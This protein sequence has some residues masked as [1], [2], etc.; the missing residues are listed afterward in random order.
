MRPVLSACSIA[1]IA[2]TVLGTTAIVHSGQLKDTFVN[3]T[4]HPAIEY[5]ARPTTDPV[6]ELNRR[7]R[8][9]TTRLQYDGPSG[10]LRSVL[11]ALNVPVESQ[12]AV[13]VKDSV[14]AARISPGNPRTIF[15]NDSVA[16]GWVRGGFVEL[17]SQ[18]PRQG[19]IF[20]RLERSW[21]GAPLFTR[22]DG[23]LACHN[24]YASTGVPGMLVR[25]VGQY[26]VDHHVPLEQRWG[27]WYVTGNHGTIEHQGN[28]ELEK[29]FDRPRAANPFN[30]PSA[31]GKFDLAGYLSPH[32]DIVALLVFEHQMHMMNLLSRI[33]W[34]ARVAAYEKRTGKTAGSV[35][36]PVPV[37][38]AA[39]EVVDYL[40][41]VDEA[42]MGDAVRG[43][44]SFA[45]KFAAQGPRDRQGRS[46]RQLDLTHRLMRYPCSYMIYSPLFEALPADAKAAIYQRM[47]TI[48][49]G[50]D[51]AAKYSRLSAVDRRAIIDILRDTKKDLPD[52]FRRG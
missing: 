15:F 24:T 30:W 21:N 37:G 8:D 19:V 45:E 41:F 35:D 9:G 48:L 26:E 47:W 12:M 2:C 36:E 14:Q 10:Y 28:V 49:S 22:S 6:A 42:P 39:R 17:A 46:L 50:T 51:K 1:A 31:A 11:D 34:E 20:Y 38:D 33:G 32:S 44:T 3:W 27:G 16:V 43:S 52:Y 25:S 18:D 13:F 7:I 5:A 40:L 23:C 4:A 29:L